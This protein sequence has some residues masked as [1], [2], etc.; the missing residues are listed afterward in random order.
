[1]RDIYEWLFGPR[2]RDGVRHPIPPLPEI[3]RPH[4]ASIA[5]TML[6]VLGACIF[7]TPPSA[8]TSSQLG[9]IPWW[10][11]GMDWPMDQGGSPLSFL[12]QVNLEELPPWPQLPAKGMLQFFI[13][14]NDLMGANPDDCSKPTGFACIYH[15]DISIGMASDIAAFMPSDSIFTPLDD[16]EKSLELVFEPGQMLMDPTD[17]RF[18]TTLADVAEDDELLEAY[19]EWITNEAAAPALRIGGYPSFTQ[20]DPRAEDD[21]LGDVSLL[22][23]DSTPGILWGDSGTAQF[24]MRQDDLEQVE[25]SR[26][27]YTWDCY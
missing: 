19:A 15:P 23:I 22:T 6:P 9:G 18:V 13:G 27:I 8:P 25:F 5:A 17:Y 20:Y 10:P 14:T 11:N 3:L 1:M 24:L 12:I 21:T 26:V 16:P 4:S 2:G 7:N